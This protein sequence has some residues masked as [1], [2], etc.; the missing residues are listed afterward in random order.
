MG[1]LRW[2]DQQTKTLL[3]SK[4]SLKAEGKYSKEPLHSLERKAILQEKIK[5]MKSKK[6]LNS[7]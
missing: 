6:N 1:N 4:S 2:R 5:A 7:K 3:L